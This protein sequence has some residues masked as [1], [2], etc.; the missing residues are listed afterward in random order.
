MKLSVTHPEG[1][2][3]RVHCH[4]IHA[5]GVLVLRARAEFLLAANSGLSSVDGGGMMST[6]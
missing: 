4:N 2:I 1:V 6:I 3:C 5:V